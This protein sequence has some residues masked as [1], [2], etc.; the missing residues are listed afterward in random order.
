MT[1]TRGQPSAAAWSRARAKPLL[2][3]S[4]RPVRLAMPRSPPAKS[5]GGALKRT[6][7]RPLSWSALAIVAAGKSYGKRNSTARKPS[8][9]AAAKRSRKACSGY[10][11]LRLA[12]KRGIAFLL[13]GSPAP[14]E[15]TAQLVDLLG[16]Q[17]RGLGIRVE[18]EPRGFLELLEARHRR[19][20]R[21]GP[22]VRAEPRQHDRADRHAESLGV[23]GA[24]RSSRS[25][26][27]GIA[28]LSATSARECVWTMQPASAAAA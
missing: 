3:S 8:R 10:I 26:F 25:S 28:R 13:S 19:G 9:A 2:N 4:S 7:C 20:R 24:S 12:A 5:P 11:M 14:A 1:C 22:D 16:R 23:L 17:R 6:C 27:A 15:A 18:P 21:A